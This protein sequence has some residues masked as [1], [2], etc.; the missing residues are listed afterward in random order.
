[1]SALLAFCKKKRKK[2][3]KEQVFLYLKSLVIVPS[4]SYFSPGPLRLRARARRPHSRLH[5]RKAKNAYS[6]RSY[7]VLFE[8]SNETAIIPQK[9]SEQTANRC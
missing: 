3:K 7:P 4:P 6:E 9:P 8:L 1:M 2:K 5:T